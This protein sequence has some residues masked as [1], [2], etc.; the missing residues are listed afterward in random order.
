RGVAS[1]LPPPLSKG[2]ADALPLRLE[3]IPAE[4]GTRDRL[5]LSL[6]QVAAAEFL[7]RRQGEA[8][9]VQRAAIWLS[10]S[11]LSPAGG[12]AIRLPERPGTLIY[13]SLGALDVDRW[14]PLVSSGDSA[15][16]ALAL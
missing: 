11:G 2:V 16:A 9:V 15:A 14:L 5:S 8:M 6:G 1:A 12:E 3:M 4:G 13:G 10:P 7:R